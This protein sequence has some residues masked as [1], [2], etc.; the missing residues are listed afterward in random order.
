[1]I[2][3]PNVLQEKPKGPKGFD[4]IILQIKPTITRSQKFSRPENFVIFANDP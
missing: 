2:K 3:V 4:A 1:M